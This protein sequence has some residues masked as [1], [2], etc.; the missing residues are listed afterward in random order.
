MTTPWS[1]VVAGCGTIGYW[2]VRSLLGQAAVLR[3]PRKLTCIDYACI[4]PQNAVTCPHY[5]SQWLGIPKSRRL[6]ELGRTWPGTDRPQVMSVHASVRQFNWLDATE[7][8][9]TLVAVVGL[10]NW[11]ARLD[12]VEGL[13][14]MSAAGGREVIIIQGG[15]DS[16]HASVGVYSGSSFEAPCPVCGLVPPLPAPEP[17]VVMTG[18]GSLLR[19]NLQEEARAATGLMCRIIAEQLANHGSWVNT[20]THI[21]GNGNGG[22]LR[23]R[24]CA[25]MPDCMGPHSAHT[26]LRWNTLMKLED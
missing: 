17:C 23:T 16:G 22:R 6:A 21:E 14:V 11:E 13:R 9:C 3:A 15:I 7:P 24:A 1:L 25:T 18:N 20:R 19:G 8:G 26:P 12:A 2:F 4:K 5:D 10:D